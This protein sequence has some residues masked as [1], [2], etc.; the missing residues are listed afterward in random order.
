MRLTLLTVLT[1]L[2]CGLSDLPANA[3]QRGNTTVTLPG[4]KLERRNG[5]FGTQQNVYSDVL[6]N[7]VESKKGLFG[8]RR[9]NSQVLGNQVRQDRWGTVVTDNQG[10]TLLKRRRGWFGRQ[11]T[12]I[13]GDGLFQR[14]KGVMNPVNPSGANPST[15]PYSN[16]NNPYGNP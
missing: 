5:W 6:G 8:W 14:M 4:V 2:L 16:P 13:N 3:Q 1:L 10:N 9:T 11:D 15:T 12:V 7:R